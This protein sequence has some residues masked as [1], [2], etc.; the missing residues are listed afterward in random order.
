[1]LIFAA[2]SAACGLAPNLAV[3]I[4]AR[5]AQGVGGALLTPTSLAILQAAGGVAITLSGGA[6]D[7]TA[8]LDGRL[9][10]EPVVIGAPA[11][12]EGLR[13]VIRERRGGQGR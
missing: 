8:L 2:A 10:P 11:H 7:T 13:A 4:A 5:A 6:L 9:L 1:M 3:L 12:A